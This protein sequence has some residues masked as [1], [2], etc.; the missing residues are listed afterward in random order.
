LSQLFFFLGKPASGKGTQ[1]KILQKEI[2]GVIYSAGDSL[3][4]H[5]ARKTDIGLKVEQIINQGSFV[6]DDLI[7]DMFFSF[8]KENISEEMPN[9]ILVDG[10]PRT[11]TQ[12]KMLSSF[13]SNFHVTNCSY[14]Y[15]DVEDSFIFERLTNRLVCDACFSPFSMTAS[16][17]REGD[18][19]LH[20]LKGKM[21]RRKDDKIEVMQKRLVD[22]SVLTAPM[23]DHIKESEKDKFYVINGE[24]HVEEIYSD[25]KTIVAKNKI[26]LKNM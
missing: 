8:L 2:G 16:S 12:Y 23:I 20:C 17:F 10:F 13:L 24:R 11:E 19:C 21:I 25:I 15:F 5:I 4:D 9:I 26:K 1:I 18:V 6:S 14:L 22:Y 3:K 7:C